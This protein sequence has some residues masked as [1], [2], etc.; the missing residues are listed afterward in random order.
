MSWLVLSLIYIT[1]GVIIYQDISSRAVTWIMF[2]ILALLGIT[3]TLIVEIPVSQL[4]TN[5]SLNIGFLL[6]Q[7]GLLYIYFRIRKSNT[8]LIN[9]KMGWGDIFFLLACCFFF[10]PLFYILFYI[11]SLFFSLI[12]FIV[13][14]KKLQSIPL[15]G[16]QAIFLL[17]FITFYKISNQHI[18]HDYFL[19]NSLFTYDH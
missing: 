17:A 14:R 2:P 13:F 1:A 19:L 9:E 4:I 7:I 5:S 6:L 10:S 8:S 18:A 11:S 12:A 15:A 3:Y 16:L